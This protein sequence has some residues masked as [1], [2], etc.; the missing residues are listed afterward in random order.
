[1]R[2]RVPD[3]FRGGTTWQPVLAAFIVF[4]VAGAFTLFAF[5]LTRAAAIESAGGEFR[6]QAAER[7]SLLQ[8]ELTRRVESLEGFGDLLQVRPARAPADFSPLSHG[9]T[10]RFPGLF[11]VAWS[12]WVPHAERGDV[13]AALR[14]E[15]YH[16]EDLYARD[17]ENR[18]VPAPESEHYLVVRQMFPEELAPDA[19]GFD[20]MSAQDRHH[21]VSR[22]IDS[23]A[24]AAT[25]PLQLGADPLDLAGTIIFVPIYNTPE[26]S[27]DVQARRASFAGTVSIGFRIGPYLE[28]W[29]GAHVSPLVQTIVYDVDQWGNPRTL[30]NHGTDAVRSEADLAELAAHPLAVTDELR[31]AG[32]I[33]SVLHVP[34]PAFEKLWKGASAPKLTLAFGLV[35]SLLLAGLAALFLRSQILARHITL[36]RAEAAADLAR[37][38][39]HLRAVN[40]DMEHFVRA[41]AHDLRG[42]LMTIHGALHLVRKQSQLPGRGGASTARLD[43][44]ERAATSMDRIIGSLVDH[45][46]AGYAPFKGDII[47]LDAL[48]RSIVNDHAEEAD[49]VGARVEVAGQMPR[50][51]GDHGRLASAFSNLISNALK[52][53]HPTPKGAPL[54]VLVGSATDDEKPL[55]AYDPSTHWAFFVRDNGPGVPRNQRGQIFAEFH[56]L[57]KPEGGVG[58]GLSIVQRAAAA[59]AGR[60]WVEDAPDGDGATFWLTVAR[61]RQDTARQSRSDLSSSV[62]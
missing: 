8:L 51:F 60:A 36:E 3:A 37:A 39:E 1:M 59:H 28:R 50:V 22:A 33:W 19:V 61:R 6:V 4:A 43:A 17:H 16:L 13:V 9:L 55:E 12:E 34:S 27:V 23:A 49:R 47:D 11:S 42:P 20:I 56:R 29:L 24:A 41:V 52:Y 46:R 38:N 18:P 7:T 14:A 57:A 58:I 15:G 62:F 54:K 2:P 45:A 5:V 21:A 26:V 31:F 10:E 25:G 40:D 30:L 48:V 32:R 35:A 53:G 44:V